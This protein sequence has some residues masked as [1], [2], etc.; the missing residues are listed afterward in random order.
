MHRG[1]T[2]HGLAFNFGAT[3]GQEFGHEI[4]AFQPGAQPRKRLIRGHHDESGIRVD[5]NEWCA[6]LP[7][8]TLTHIA[9]D[10]EPS[11]VTHGNG[12]R[13]IGH[14]RDD[15]TKFIEWE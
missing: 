10:D 2:S 14:T 3:L 6:L 15:T 7:C 5:G 9:R 12:V 11:T 4:P 13:N 1:Q 8:V